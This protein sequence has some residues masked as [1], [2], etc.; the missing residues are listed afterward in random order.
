MTHDTTAF[1]SLKDMF[2]VE[3]K[4]GDTLLYPESGRYGKIS[5]MEVTG[6]KVGY[7]RNRNWDK[8]FG[9]HLFG[10]PAG[11][12]ARPVWIHYP[13]NAINITGTDVETVYAAWA[14]RKERA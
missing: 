14:E 6:I 5:I 13:K 8:V 4:I 1:D 12:Q 2:G 11:S 9:P 7:E 3:I 10:R